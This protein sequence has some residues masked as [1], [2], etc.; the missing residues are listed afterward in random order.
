MFAITAVLN[1]IR[2]IHLLSVNNSYVHKLDALTKLLILAGFII[3]VTSFNYAHLERLLYFACYLLLL[4][5]LSRTPLGIFSLPILISLPIVLGVGLLN[6]WLGSETYIQFGRVHIATKYVTLIS[7][8]VKSV[9]TL[10]ATTLLITTTTTLDI[11]RSLYRLRLPNILILQFMLLF[12]YI[13][14]LLQEAVNINNAYSLRSGKASIEFKDYPYILGQ[15]FLA[16]YSR[17]QQVYQAM[18][19][20][21]FEQE[22]SLPTTGRTNWL[23]IVVNIGV[24]IY[25]R[26]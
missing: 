9:L 7:L 4:I 24:F 6:F 8:L 1:R 17:A 14:V 15:L 5:R 26:L 22:Y 13:S 23:L 10:S 19:C 20:R 12:N 11:Y 3:T 2:Q 18:L 25:W 21:G 16:S